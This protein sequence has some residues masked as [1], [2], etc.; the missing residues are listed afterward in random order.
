VL[1]LLLAIRYIER[2]NKLLLP[3]VLLTFIL[4]LLSKENAITYLGVVP[5]TFYYFT[6]AEKKDYLVVCVPML[7]IAGIYV[8]LR[9]QFT[10]VEVTAETKEILNNPFVFATTAE[11]LATVAFTFWEYIRLL[12]VPHP[13]T[14]D[15]YFN[16][17][18]IIGWDSP[19]AILPFLLN[20]SIL[21]WALIKIRSKNIFSYAILYYFITISIVSNIFFTVGIAMNERFVFMPSLGFCIIMAALLVKTVNYIKEKNFASIEIKYPKPVVITLVL[22]L[23]AYSVKT[24]TRNLDWKNDFTLFA[25][26]YKNSPNS[27][28]IRN[29]YG[30]ELVTRAD[31][32]PEP[33]RTEYLKK[34]EQVLSEALKIYPNYQ[35]ALLLMGNAKYKLYDSLPEARWYYEQ[36]IK[37]RPDYYEGNFNLGTILLAKKHYA[38]SIPYLK[39][40]LI[41]GSDKFEPWFYLGDAYM[42]LNN[43]DSAIYYYQN[44]L[45]IKPNTAIVHYKIGLCY[46][47]LKNDFSNGFAHLNKAIQLDPTNHTFY[48]DL[49]VAHGI[50]QEYQKAIEA[51]ERG[52]KVKPDYPPFYRNLGITYQ[53]LG[54]EAK[55][56]EY[57][58]KAQE[59]AARQQQ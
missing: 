44:A 55:A 48:E 51:F 3:F 15:Y 38:E 27:A 25:A 46:A 31:E 5:L 57:F 21:I 10:D 32:V 45:K 35:N 41:K 28:K 24:Y 56:K 2:K 34:A 7:M 50:N 16:Q 39:K 11:R 29:S 17:V 42:N 43:A 36:T 47:K 13:L 8:I 22:I 6:N 52:I 19:K 20:A 53:Q 37:M 4:A 23:A 26:D 33:T 30:G 1:T 58:A 40:S 9:Q 54:N 12:L 18:P 14:H 49:G 59:L